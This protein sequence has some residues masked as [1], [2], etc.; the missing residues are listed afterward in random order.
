[1]NVSPVNNILGTCPSGEELIAFYEGELPE[2]AL[3]RV[4]EHIEIPCPSCIAVLSKLAERADPLLAEF[5][6]PL[7]LSAAEAEA[8]YWSALKHVLGPTVSTTDWR[9]PWSPVTATTLDRERP[10]L[11]GYEILTPPIGGHHGWPKMGGMGVVWLVRDPQLQR[12]LALKV[13]KAE[14]ADSRR[15]CRFLL[16]ARI[17]AQLAHPSIVPVHAMGRLDDFRPYYLMKLVEGDTLADRLKPGSDVTSQR[18]DLLQVF[19]RVCQALAFAHKKGV[20]HRDLKPIH[21]MVG[22]H[23]EVLIIDWGLAKVLGQSDVLVPAELSHWPSPDGQAMGTWPY[24]PPEQANGRIEEMD[25]RS[26]V[27]GLGGILCAILTGKPPYVGPTPEDVMRQVCDA[28][29]A[30]ARARLQGCGADAQ[31]IALARDCLS[32]EPNDRPPD[33]SAVEERLASYLASVQERLQ[34]SKVAEAEARARAEQAERTKQLAEEKA[35]AERR[36]RELAEENE[37]Q[38]KDAWR[39]MLRL[40]AWLGCALLALVAASLFA[41]RA[42]DAELAA[43]LAREAEKRQHAID[44]ALTAAMGADLEGADQAIAEAEQAGASPGQLHMRRGQIALHRGQSRDAIRHLKEAVR[45]LPDSVAARGML[46]AAYA[47]DGQWERYDQM[48][49]EMEQLTASTPEDFLFKGYAEAN[50]EPEKGLQTM[51]QAFDLR[52]MMGVALLLR[53]EVRALVAQDMDDLEEAKEAVQD[54]K[55]AR[56]LLRN[57]PAALWVSLEAHLA[58]AGVHEHHGQSDQRRAELELAGKD[59]DALKPFIALPEAVVYR[60]L[61]FRE[62]GREEEVLEE[63]RLASEQTD[64]VYVAFCYALTLYRRGQP[65]DFEEALRVLKTRRGTY[66]DRLLPFVLAEHDYPNNHDWPARARK[67]C[68]DLTASG[69]DG[70]AV[71]DTQTVLFLLGEKGDAVK[72]S[73]ALLEQPERFCTLR[74]EPILR[75]LRYKA[76]APDLPADEL[77]RLAGRSRWDQ[78]LAHYYIAMTKLAEEDRKGAQEHLDQVIKTRAFIWGPYDMSWVFQARLAKDPTWPRWIPERKAK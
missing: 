77:V 52:P 58:K 17:T 25:R 18:V 62:V 72:A 67:A 35:E 5:R 73:K 48:I 33:A 26:D 6:E 20:I 36:A 11:P 53:A 42:H 70:V 30:G 23:G 7:P 32:P 61:Y 59:A 9:P 43:E 27:F 37:R 57:N 10:D 15:V 51:K 76:G 54:A 24:M 41:W 49:G 31:L 78:C 14:G 38:A 19:A 60:W 1:M 74:R 28:D 68:D 8:A 21:V 29:L 4:A 56:E 63:L 46:A 66:A 44:T 64:H 3:N 65:G 22:E 2:A 71:M 55:Y 34:Q 50:L 40:M 45:L 47:S 69:Q 39:R 75:C 13:M 16:E 12:P